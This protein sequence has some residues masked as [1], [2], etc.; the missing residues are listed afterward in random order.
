MLSA[1]Y[2]RSKADSNAVLDFSIDNVLFSPQAGGP[3][4]W[5][6]PNRF[7]SSGYMPLPRNFTIA[8]SLDWRDGFPFSLVEMKTSNWSAHPA[9]YAFPNISL[10]TYKSSGAFTCSNSCGHWRAGCN[11]ITNRPNPSGVNNNVDSPEFLTYGGIQGR[12]VTA[13]VRL[14]GRK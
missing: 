4:P 7:L 12:A 3:L 13:R 10:S 11:D 2:T 5:D 14:L 8:Y 9:P 1:S 6:T